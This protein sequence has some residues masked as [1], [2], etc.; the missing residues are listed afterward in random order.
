MLFQE[1][2]FEEMNFI[3]DGAV[4]LATD[5]IA[6]VA[7]LGSAESSLQSKC[8]CTT[9][10]LAATARYWPTSG[11]TAGSTTPLRR[12][13]KVVFQ[14]PAPTPRRV[15]CERYGRKKTCDAPANGATNVASTG[16]S[17]GDSVA[18]ASV[19]STSS[20]GVAVVAK[21]ADDRGVDVSDV[22][23]ADEILRCGVTAST[24]IA[25]S[26]EF[27]LTRVAMEGLLFLKSACRK[28]DSGKPESKDLNFN[29][30]MESKYE[31]P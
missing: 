15:C 28:K 31:H 22:I 13:R 25:G 1:F 26:V 17:V 12:R 10:S 7:G 27:N 16:G 3:R 20:C 4:G 19:I 21:G 11:G 5:A 30:T 8:C 18:S 2:I 23:D 14:S 6:P 24:T 29:P 9:V